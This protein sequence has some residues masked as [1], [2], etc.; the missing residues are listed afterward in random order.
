MSARRSIGLFF[1][2]ADGC[3][4]DGKLYSYERLDIVAD[5]S[6]VTVCRN[7]ADTIVDCLNCISRQSIDIEHIVIDGA[8]SDGTIDLIN[9]HRPQLAH[10]ISEPDR[11]I[12]DAMNKGLKLASGDVIGILNADD[13]YP[14]DATLARVTKTFDDLD[15]EACYGDLIYV[16]DKDINKIKRMWHAGGFNPKQFYWGWMPPHPTFFVRRSVYERHG[17]FNLELGSAADYE[18]MLRFLLKYKIKV[19]YIPEVLVRMRMGG[20]SNISLCNRIKAN[21]MDRKAWKVNDLQPY[22]WTLIAKPLRKLK[23]WFVR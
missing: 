10:I 2:H 9:N 16:D 22:P 7:A 3:A 14:N 19:A 17:Y 11:G 23:Q 1:A 18:L 15:I 4:G 20:V 8:S 5:I 21:R 13:L 12:Y 6:I